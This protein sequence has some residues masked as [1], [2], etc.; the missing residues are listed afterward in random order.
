MLLRAFQQLRVKVSCVHVNSPDLVHDAFVE[1]VPH[2]RVASR[3]V[4]PH[5]HALRMCVVTTPPQC[6]ASK[7]SKRLDR[8]AHFDVARW[9]VSQFSV[10]ILQRMV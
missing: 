9:Q 8:D 2:R 4:A 5:F 10:H 1:D 6:G 3:G 7:A